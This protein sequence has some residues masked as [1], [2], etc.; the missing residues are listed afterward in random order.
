M[1]TV[2]KTY[3]TILFYTQD[4]TQ[5][6]NIDSILANSL[7]QSLAA[8]SVGNA[9]VTEM[10]NFSIITGG[11]ITY[12]HGLEIS[13]FVDATFVPTILSNIPNLQAAFPQ[14]SITTWGYPLTFGF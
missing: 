12:N 4:Q 5:P 14:Y 10:I 13:C 9:L 6:I 3:Q 11:V 8:N 7:M 2:A 1:A